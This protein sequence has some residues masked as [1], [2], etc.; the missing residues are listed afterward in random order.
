[1][2]FHASDADC[3]TGQLEKKKLIVIK[4]SQMTFYKM[5]NVLMIKSSC[6]ICSV[7]RW[8]NMQLISQ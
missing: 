2:P 1:M 8:L 7:A 5:S 3:V 6:G 4:L